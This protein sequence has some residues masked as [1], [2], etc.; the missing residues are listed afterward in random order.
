[1]ILFLNAVVI[2][3]TLITL[4]VIVIDIHGTDV[5]F[6]I[7][8]IVDF[9]FCCVI[10]IHIRI[11]LVIIAV[12]RVIVVMVIPVGT[13]FPKIIKLLIISYQIP[14]SPTILPQLLPF[15]RVNLLSSQL[16]LHTTFIIFKN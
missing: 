6:E 14:Y 1:M 10:H 3:I 16:F 13:V 8:S 2:T 11:E 9:Y 4:I 5:L 12:A 15:L 7:F